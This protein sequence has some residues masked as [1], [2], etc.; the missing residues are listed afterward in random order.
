[1][2]AALVG[3]L[4][5][6][7]WPAEDLAVVEVAEGRRDTLK[8][9]FTGVA[10]TATVPPCDAA[11]IAVKPYDAAEAATAAAAAGARRVLSIAAGV[12][13]D[14]LQQAW[15]RRRCSIPNARRY[16]A[17]EPRRC[18]RSSFAT[19]E[20]TSARGGEAPQHG[21]HR[22][23]SVPENLVDKSRDLVG[24]GPAYLFPRRRGDCSTPACLPASSPDRRRIGAPTVGRVRSDARQYGDPVALRAMVTSPRRH[25]RRR[26]AGARERRPMGVARSRV[27]CHDP[28]PRTRQAPLRNRAISRRPL[29]APRKPTNP[30]RCDSFSMACLCLTF[31]QVKTPQVI[32]LRSRIRKDAPTGLCHRGWHRPLSILARGSSTVARLS[33]WAAATRP[34]HC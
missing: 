17:R 26:P 8:T 12:S 7:G 25:H 29:A 24:S 6:G 14:A 5:A 27:R 23:G 22:S 34:F 1:M 32:S 18:V 13:I 30:F 11:L 31:S 19:D 33:P 20:R 16:W 9:M 3:G 10:V 15:Q 28:K 21:R 2:G 4:I